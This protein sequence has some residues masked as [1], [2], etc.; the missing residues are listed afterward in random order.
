M[1]RVIAKS[2]LVRFWRKHA[3]AEG[4]LRA[5]HAEVKKASW[6]T[7]I[8]IKDR[9]ASASILGDQR[10]AFNIGGNKYRLIVKIHYNTGIVFVRFIGTH[11]EYD[12][13]EAEEI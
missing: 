4:P 1:M 3:D 13:I 5:W 6:Q 11:A 12:A 7:A 8:E 9:Y 10:I 2:T